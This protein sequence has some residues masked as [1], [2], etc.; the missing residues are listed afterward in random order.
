MKKTNFN[1]PN[2]YNLLFHLSPKTRARPLFEDM[3]KH[4]SCRKLP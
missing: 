4:Y 1:K 3:P 2:D